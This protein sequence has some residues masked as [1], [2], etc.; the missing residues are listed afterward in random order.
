MKIKDSIIILGIIISNTAFS[1]D[2][3]ETRLVDKYYPK[4][5]TPTP[6]PQNNITPI[7]RNESLNNGP[8]Q[9]KP[10]I[11]NSPIS[12]TVV[13]Q[14]TQ[15]PETKTNDETITEPVTSAPVTDVTPQQQETVIK[16]EPVVSQ[17]APAPVLNTTRTVTTTPTTGHVYRD[18]R[19]GS[20]SPQYDTYEKNNYGA[21]SVTTNPNKNGGGAG[22]EMTSPPTTE[23]ATQNSAQYRNR[24]G[25]SSPLYD[26]YE[27]NNYGA[28]SVT[29]S[30]K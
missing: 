21:G 19:L 15:A 22:M 29:T 27:K 12:G 24:L 18:T 3:T 2:T 26:T 6:A 8:V 23:S 14:P 4:S 11:N 7:S 25:S 5:E 17:P 13:A 20:S 30:P 16:N 1:Q 9:Q 28:G 10:A